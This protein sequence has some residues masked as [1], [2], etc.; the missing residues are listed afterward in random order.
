MQIVGHV[1]IRLRYKLSIF[2]WSSKLLRFLKDDRLSR[3][4]GLRKGPATW[5]PGVISGCP[6][7]QKHILINLIV[8]VDRLQFPTSSQATD[9]SS[10]FG[11][12]GSGPMAAE[13]GTFCM[14]HKRIK[15]PVLMACMTRNWE[16]G[17]SQVQVGSTS[18]VECVLVLSSYCMIE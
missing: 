7:A 13:L 1:S 4:P 18:Y 6:E 14:I 9:S 2:L 12:D 15:R 8:P 16:S 3:R 17:T 5:S 11:R 10:Q